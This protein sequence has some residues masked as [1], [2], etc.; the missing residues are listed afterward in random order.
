MTL[1]I[2]TTVED[3]QSVCG[4]LATKPTGATLAQAKTVLDS[5][6]LD[7]RKLN[8]LK[9][10]N[11]IVQEDEKLKATPLGREAA[12]DGTSLK[13][14]LN[15]VIREMPPYLAIIE[16]VS[17][18]N[19]DNISSLDVAAH[20]NDH[21]KDESGDSDRLANDQAVAFFNIAE[22][23]GLGKRCQDEEEMRLDLIFLKQ[24]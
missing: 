2:R 6:R 20:W 21:F 16:R 4:Y 19:E 3:I 15:Q 10:W 23:A 22:G 12:K 1:P 17:H 8:A 24:L 14:A 5:K 13:E 9:Q 11:L 18:K 7:S